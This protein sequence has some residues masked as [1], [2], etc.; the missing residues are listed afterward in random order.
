MTLE[1]YRESHPKFFVTADGV[2]IVDG[3][4]VWDHDLKRSVVNIGRTSF[5]YWH[6]WFEM[7][8]PNG[9]RAPIMNGERLRVRHPSTGEKA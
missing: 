7:A 8:Y 9:D 3:M 6:G 1:S 4:T 5:V 2:E